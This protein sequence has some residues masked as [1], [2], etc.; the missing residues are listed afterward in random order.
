M[1][2]SQTVNKKPKIPKPRAFTK[3]RLSN[4]AKQL[5]ELPIY[6]E[7]LGNELVLRDVVDPRFSSRLHQIAR[8][9]SVSVK[10][11]TRFDPESKIMRVYRLA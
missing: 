10:I 5:L 1:N 7:A 9:E 3:P 8:G 6:D 4:L 2:D 11:T